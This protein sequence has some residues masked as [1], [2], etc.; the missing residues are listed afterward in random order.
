MAGDPTDEGFKVTDRRGRSQ[1]DDVPEA[2]P[3]EVP[4]APPPAGDQPSQPS[5]P[6][7]AAPDLTSLFVMFATSALIAMGEAP[8]PVSGRVERNLAQAG[9]AIDL[10]ILLRTKTEGNRTPDEDQV[11]SQLLYDLQMRFVGAKKAARS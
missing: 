11:L 7:G 9:E 10:L 3:R 6:P 1:S 8:D 2:P 5:A 4:G